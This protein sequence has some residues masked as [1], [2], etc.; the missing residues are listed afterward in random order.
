MEDNMKFV[1]SQVSAVERLLHEMEHPLSDSGQFEVSLKKERKTCLL[2]SGFLYALSPPP[3]FVS[4][5]PV[6]G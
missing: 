2:A 5:A 3:V 4:A 6:P 1:G